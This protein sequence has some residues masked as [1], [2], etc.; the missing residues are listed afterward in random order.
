MW[1]QLSHAE[2]NS[3]F[4]STADFSTHLLNRVGAKSPGQCYRLLASWIGS[5]LALANKPTALLISH[6][7]FAS[8]MPILTRHMQAAGASFVCPVL[9]FDS[10]LFCRYAYRGVQSTPR[11]V[12]TPRAATPRGGTPITTTASA[13]RGIQSTPRGWRHNNAR[14][15]PD[16]PAHHAM[17][18]GKFILN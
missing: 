3:A 11:V 17:R 13:Y 5:N 16:G 18:H 6:N 9:F 7:C 12:A 10:L 14:A 15:A 2:I 8:D 1:P 4:T